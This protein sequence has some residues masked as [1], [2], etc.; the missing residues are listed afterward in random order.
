MTT[1]GHF[2]LANLAGMRSA[3]SEPFHLTRNN[4]SASVLVAAMILSA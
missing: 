4:S 1:S 3:S 2:M